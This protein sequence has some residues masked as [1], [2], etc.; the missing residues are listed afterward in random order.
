MKRITTMQKI[1]DKIQRANGQC[2]NQ[3]GVALVMVLILAVISLAMVSV[4]IY[5]VTQGTRFSGFYKRY[6]TAREAGI[7]GAEI[8][9]ALIMGRG[10]NN[11]G[12]TLTSTSIGTGFLACS[13]GDPDDATDNTDSAGNRTCLCD[14][15]CSPTADWPSA[16]S[17]T[18]DPLTDYD[19][20][21]SLASDPSDL[22]KPTY[23]VSAKMLIQLWG[24]LI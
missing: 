22:S 7:G 13:C 10:L 11:S 21:L 20:R 12:L 8:A 14:K 4:M 24:T 19:M 1:K 9:G 17:S 2:L 18:L 5:L 23:E 15:L 6:E 16:C 3:R